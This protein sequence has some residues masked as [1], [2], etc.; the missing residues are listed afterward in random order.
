MSVILK[1]SPVGH[2]EE[3]FEKE[4]VNDR[5]NYYS[6]EE[7]Q[8]GQWISKGAEVFGLSGKVEQEDFI[9]LSRGVNP[10]TGKRFRR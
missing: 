2:A 7:T 6:V 8:S 5:E 9:K 1:K 4:L 3:Y 10:D